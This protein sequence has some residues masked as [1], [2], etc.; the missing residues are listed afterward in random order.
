[1][2]PV[3]GRGFNET[4]RSPEQSNCTPAVTLGVIALI[5]LS[6]ILVPTEVAFLFSTV[7]VVA[8]LSGTNCCRNPQLHFVI[9]L[10]DLFFRCLSGLTRR[11][12]DNHSTVYRGNYAQAPYGTRAGQLS[13]QPSAIRR[14][15]HLPYVQT[16]RNPIF[17]VA[18][19]PY[20]TATEARRAT[21]LSGAPVVFQTT[22]GFT[23][24]ERAQRDDS[25]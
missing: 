6:F 11:D 17:G 14:S 18:A 16:V 15:H 2:D 9:N 7:A 19:A 3:L 22:S 8:L 10:T 4:P 1:M 23:P 24:P 21:S 12:Q 25:L 20:G 13:G 5:P